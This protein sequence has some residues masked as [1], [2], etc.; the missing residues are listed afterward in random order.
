MQKLRLSLSDYRRSFCVDK[1]NS[2]LHQ[3]LFGWTKRSFMLRLQRSIKLRRL[4]HAYAFH[5]RLVPTYRRD[6][7][8]WQSID[9][10]TKYI[11][12]L[13]VVRVGIEFVLSGSL[14]V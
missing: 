8:T 7:A 10:A 13:S 9:A 11:A 3:N 6:A 2:K 5:R 14:P 4:T 12:A 1:K